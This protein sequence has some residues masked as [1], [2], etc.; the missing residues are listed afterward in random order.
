MI[1]DLDERLQTER[2]IWIATV[3]PDGRPHLTPIWFVWQGARMWICTGASAVKTRNVRREPHVM[4]SLESGDSPVVGVG[5]VVVH[6][7]PYPPA[8]VDAFATKFEWDITDPDDK[9]GPFEALWE[10]TIERW[11][12]G[13]PPGA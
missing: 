3:S 9:D 5:T 7:R 4:V 8:V 13:G 11:L 12:M 6:E 10:I 1:V 2:N